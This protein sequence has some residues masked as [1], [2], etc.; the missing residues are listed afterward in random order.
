[1][2]VKV[3]IVKERPT[4]FIRAKFFDLVES[5][6]FDALIMTC[7][8]LN[9]ATMAMVFEESSQEYNSILE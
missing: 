4:N 8:L 9:I 6:Y 7:I 1:M 3:G 5:G 2:D